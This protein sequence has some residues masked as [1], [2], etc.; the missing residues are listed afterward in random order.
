MYICSLKIFSFCISLTHSVITWN[1]NRLFPKWLKIEAELTPNQCMRLVV[2]L[3]FGHRFW[4]DFV[5]LIIFTLTYIVHLGP[6]SIRY[7]YCFRLRTIQFRRCQLYS[8]LSKH[9][10][11]GLFVVYI[12]FYVQSQ[13]YNHFV[14]Y[15]NIV[16]AHWNLVDG[17][18][19]HTRIWR[20]DINLSGVIHSVVSCV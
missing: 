17:L 1:N 5:H 13:I 8:L 10:N 20:N 7:F 6:T 18:W 19:A 14:G 15:T 16:I 4:R 9:G 3:P 11:C 12:V 2:Y